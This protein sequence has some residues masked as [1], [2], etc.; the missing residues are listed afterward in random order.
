MIN[1]D[2]EVIKYK[3][4]NNTIE[5]SD[6]LPAVVN[7]PLSH[8]QSIQFDHIK[9]NKVTIDKMSSD[10]FQDTLKERIDDMVEKLEREKLYYNQ[11]SV[12]IPNLITYLKKQLSTLKQF[13]VTEYDFQYNEP[14]GNLKNHILDDPIEIK[15][16]AINFDE[17]EPTVLKKL[18]QI[19][20]AKRNICNSGIQSLGELIGKKTSVKTLK[21]KRH[22]FEYNGSLGNLRDFY[23]RL[24]T[25]RDKKGAFIEDIEYK[26]FKKVFSNQKIQIKINWIGHQNELHFLI[27][28]MLQNPKFG[29]AAQRWALSRKCFTLY[30]MPI[31][32]QK[33]KDADDEPQKRVGELLRIIGLLD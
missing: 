30:N 32:I 29:K 7:F 9:M 15:T 33:L 13:D 14:I 28:R 23:E 11:Y 12:N 19:T 18:H 21:K 1:E 22:S 25:P 8:D 31:D 26:E 6:R 24:L 5:I 3:L 17:L 2:F 20:E 27:D 16:R 4:E 10:D